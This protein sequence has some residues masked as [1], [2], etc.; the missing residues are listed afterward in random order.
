MTGEQMTGDGP[1]YP[2]LRASIKVVLEAVG[3][4]LPFNTDVTVVAKKAFQCEKTGVSR[5][6]SGQIRVKPADISRLVLETTIAR[7][8]I[9]PEHFHDGPEALRRV[10]R[11]RGVGIYGQ[12][13]G[14]RLSRAVRDFTGDRGEVEVRPG[15]PRAA[16]FVWDPEEAVQGLAILRPGDSLH[17]ACRG[18]V[19][20]RLLLIDHAP[21]AGDPALLAPAVKGDW[22]RADTSGRTLFPGRDEG[23]LYARPDQILRQVVA[24]WLPETLA[25]EIDKAVPSSEGAFR[26]VPDAPYARILGSLREGSGKDRARA[27]AD[28]LYRSG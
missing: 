21:D 12:S 4:R 5:R 11:E 20:C 25:S 26:A 22:P 7:D 10:L 17:F 3:Y 15:R 23:P 8:G 9:G 27:V 2:D 14:S 24:L 6:L 28:V 19:D 1:R 16:G 13:A 18:P